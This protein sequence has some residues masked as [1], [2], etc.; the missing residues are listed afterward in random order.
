M[1]SSAC[2]PVVS[3]H[4]SSVSQQYHVTNYITF[5]IRGIPF[6]SLFYLEIENDP[7]YYYYKMSYIFLKKLI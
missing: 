3:F 4:I 6:L 2:I 1:L 5:Y 7:I